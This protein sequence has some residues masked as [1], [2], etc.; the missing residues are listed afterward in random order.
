ME[1]AMKYIAHLGEL[2]PAL[3]KLVVGMMLYGI[4]LKIVTLITPRDDW[5]LISEGKTAP[6]I[7][8][9]GATIGFLYPLSVV[10]GE[11]HMIEFAEAAL[12][13]CVVQ[14]VWLVVIHWQMHKILNSDNVG[15]AILYASSAIGFGM[16]TGSIARSILIA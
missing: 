2:G 9:A 1:D 11:S 6:S 14:S 4:F 5:K 13:A 7:M 10:I 16:L 12:L 8:L 3:V 15:A